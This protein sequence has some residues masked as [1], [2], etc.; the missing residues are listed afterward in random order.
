MPTVSRDDG[1]EIHWEARG[2]GPTVVLA[3]YW[4]WSPGVYDELFDL[5][6]VDHR[7]VTYHLRG[8]GESSREGPYEMETD[9][10]DLEAVL[11]AAGGP[12]LLLGIADSANRACRLA[13]RRADLAAAV[14]C[15]GT[16][17]I[18]RAAFEGKEA[19][20]ASDSVVDAFL[21]MLERDYRGAT[22]TLMTATNPQMSEDELRRRVGVQVEF[23]PQ[24]PAVGRLRAWVEDD[25]REE[26]RQ[27]G[28]RLVILAS[29]AVAG[30]WLPPFDE[31]LRMTRSQFP[32]AQI[33]FV[34]PG[35][36]SRPDLA[37][38]KIRQ[39]SAE[40]RLSAPAGRQ[41]R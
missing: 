16:A 29:S 15:I 40:L 31:M 1:V 19:M 17:P 12:A 6:A 21:K 39:I 25:P 2:E 38:E 27:L 26:A 11:E 18:A 14:A 34:E 36:V 4:S 37:A 5:L 10:A 3:S 35:P 30:P 8:T 32:S 41:D 22:R 7:V 20:L 23:C 28:D 13:L 24:E 33:D 9:T